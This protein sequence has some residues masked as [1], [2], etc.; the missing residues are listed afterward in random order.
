MACKKLRV[1]CWLSWHGYASGS[2]GGADLRMV[3]LM[4][5]PPTISCSSESRLQLP[6][7]FYFSGADSPGAP[8]QSPRGP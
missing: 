6:S 8:G 2:Q 4:P 3:Q 7:W 1:G 5:L